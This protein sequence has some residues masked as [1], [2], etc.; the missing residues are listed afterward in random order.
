M[1]HT[2]SHTT[3]GNVHIGTSG[4]WYEDWKAIVY[5]DRGHHDP[6]AFMARYFDALE[7]NVSFYRDV[8]QAMTESWLR[9]VDRM[10]RFQFTAKLHQR[11][12]HQRVEPLA[13]GEVRESLAG[14]RPIVEA[15]RLGALL[16][17]FPWSFRDEPRSRDW[18]R[19]V[20]DAC[21]ESPLVV[22][23]RHDSW[24]APEALEFLR[25]LDVGFCNIDQP[26]LDHCIPPTET[27]FAPVGYVRLHGR[28]HVRWFDHNGAAER[29]DYLYTE[30]EID[31]WVPRIRRIAAQA[32]VTFVFTNNH[33]RGQAPANALELMAKLRGEPVDVPS[34]LLDAYPVLAKYA[35]P[36][37]HDRQG[38]LF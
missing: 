25:S 28:N 38:R 18:L 13:A 22:E 12:T 23:V 36:Q 16:A 21:S 37:K 33:F 17:Q 20:R 26:V 6:L 34:A 35:R 19:H 15:G 10:P 32:K 1:A 3:L 29:Y 7:I 24:L 8:T 11:F 27:V 30:H 9:R 14:L 5:S 2:A 4:W 31:S